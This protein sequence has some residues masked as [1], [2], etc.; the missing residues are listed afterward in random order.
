MKART[1]VVCYRLVDFSSCWG[2]WFS[3]RVSRLFGSCWSLF[4]DW[5]AVVGA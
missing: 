5:L 4:L 3:L 1:F 2:L